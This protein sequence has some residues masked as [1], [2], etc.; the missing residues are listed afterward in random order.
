MIKLKI[1][2]WART[3]WGSSTYTTEDFLF[4]LDSIIASMLCGLCWGICVRCVCEFGF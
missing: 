2:F 1:I 4:R 3:S